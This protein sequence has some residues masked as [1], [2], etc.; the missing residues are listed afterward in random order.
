M[1]GKV[2]P[3]DQGYPKR[4]PDQVTTFDVLSTSTVGWRAN[5]DT[6]V[7]RYG[8]QVYSQMANDEQVKAVLNFKRD[9]ITARGWDW[10][11]P[12]T[13]SL[14]EDEQKKRIRVF[15]K[16]VAS[17]RGAFV[18]G[19]NAIMTGRAFGFSMT[20]K[21]Y[22]E[23]E[24]DGK[25]WPAINML[26]GRDP[27]SFR[28]Y[29]DAYGTLERAEQQTNR[30]GTVDVDLRR[31]IHY[32]HAPEWD[33]VYGRSDLREAYRAW[34]IKQEVSKLWPLYLERFAGGL[35]HAELPAESSLTTDELDALK[36]ALGRA[37]SLGYLMTPGGV[38]VN[39][40]Q[41][42]PT[43]AYERAIQFQDLAIAKALLVPNLLGIS[44]TGETGAYAQSQT[45]LEAF[46]WTLNADAARLVACL[47]E[48]LFRDLGDQAWG[49]GDY[50]E[51][52]FKPASMEHVRWIVTTWA[53]LVTAKAVQTSEQDE[54]H[55][56]EILEMPPRVEDEDDEDATVTSDPAT[57]FTGVQINAMMEV[58]KAVALG[59]IPKG[60]AEIILV[61]SFPISVERARALLADV[62]EGSIK[63]PAPMV[64]A[65]GAFPP[66]DGVTP[67]A[68]A[69]P[70][71]KQTSPADKPSAERV[72]NV[73]VTPR[74]VSMAVMRRAIERVD[75]AQI[76]RRSETLATATVEDTA[77]LIARYTWD[78]LGN[79]E[80]MRELLDRD[81]ADIQDVRLD[82]AS[83][84]KAMCKQ[85]LTRAWQLGR[86]HAAREM[87]KARSI[88]HMLAFASNLGDMAADW[89]EA[90]GA[91]MATN[92]SDGAKAI[93]Q[94]ELL[95]G[96]KQGTPTAQVSARIYDRLIRRGFTTLRALET[97]ATSA[98]LLDAVGDLLADALGTTAARIPAYLNTLVRTNT[99]EALN[100]ARHAYFESPDLAGFVLAYEYSAILDD[101][102][103]DFCRHMDGFVRAHDDD[104]WDTY[105]PPN[106]FNC[107]S[108]LIPVTQVDGWN[109]IESPDP[110]MD[111]ADGF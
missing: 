68:P 85:G 12:E 95:L 27:L 73:R 42:P 64:A 87:A 19:L 66:S 5:P 20:E 86:E 103:T 77:R 11:F 67:S 52:C 94:Q 84:I 111:P 2:V 48:Q 96:V 72:L 102:T 80:R 110:R 51:F 26:L 75:F 83:A 97:E 54:A 108:L 100:E 4:R 29:T 16:A 99:F 33:H 39:I 23:I 79:A 25:Q 53:Q 47:N 109:G 81:V 106:H 37:K 38:K 24:L 6:L 45:Q 43:D 62:V 9:A 32:V 101:R 89:I 15:G 3:L 78:I 91:R 65:P 41:P 74:V 70:T 63:P 90:N 104:I 44:H 28:F 93:I 61:E 13:S 8:L 82:G 18:D 88:P 98:E 22:G 36:D 14:S 21:V 58:V 10:T 1:A 60:T 107:R 50:P 30:A 69:S 46:F 31:V 57:A 105:R 59:D 7:G 76:D 71:D 40:H 55:L 56:R 34:Y 49:D 35:L 92:L 17:M